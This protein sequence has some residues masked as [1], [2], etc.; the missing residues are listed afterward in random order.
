M[1]DLNSLNQEQ[2]NSVTV[3]YDGGKFSVHVKVPFGFLWVGSFS[4]MNE[5]ITTFDVAG[6][7][8]PKFDSVS[9]DKFLS[10]MI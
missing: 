8:D 7:K 4:D 10:S 6:I 2:K 1:T 9:Y 5:M 3:T